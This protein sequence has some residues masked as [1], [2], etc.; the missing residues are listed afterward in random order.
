VTGSGTQ[1]K[2]SDGSVV[3]LDA[4]S[5]RNA[6]IKGLYAEAANYDTT[7]ARALLLGYDGSMP[8]TAYQAAFDAVHQQAM[9]GAD[10][11]TAVKQAGPAALL[12]PDDAKKLAYNTGK[13]LFEEN[14]GK[15]IQEEIGRS[16]GLQQADDQFY[17]HS[18]PNNKNDTTERENRTDNIITFGNEESLGSLTKFDN[19]FIKGEGI[20]PKKRGVL[21]AHNMDYFN[22]TLESMGFPLE[23]LKVG[24]PIPH[25]TI[26]GIY[27]QEYRLPAYDGRGN[28]IGFKNIPDP[29]TIYDPRIISDKQM[30]EW[31]Q[32][33]MKKGV[34]TGRII[35]G[36]ASN[37]LTFRGFINN[38]VVTN[39][40]PVL[41]Q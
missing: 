8:T 22:S 9:Q 30:L 14:G 24:E 11:E 21:G 1:V 20:G 26:K 16:G 10:I 39:F 29:K 27:A 37:G 19:H 7:T 15:I 25:P 12:L 36:T 32:E 13:L 2:L 6:E 3:P 41:P 17:T 5:F 34:I 40:F 18:E 4:V 35:E 31:G 38:G 28:F 23:Q 33:A